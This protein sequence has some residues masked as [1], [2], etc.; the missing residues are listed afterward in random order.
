MQDLLTLTRNVTFVSRTDI[1]LMR[2]QNEDNFYVPSAEQANGAA[3]QLF[4]V[5][6]GMG[7]HRGGKM[8]SQLAVDT[9]AS[10]Y[11]T[12]QPDASAEIRIV[13][14]VQDANLKVFETSATVPEFFGMGT[15]LTSLVVLGSEAI[16][17]HVGDSR[18]YHF[19][20]G[21][22]TQVTL[23]HSLVAQA[24]REGILTPE[25]A[26]IHP[27]RNIITKALGTR[28]DIEVDTAHVALDAGDL[29]LLSSD[30]LHGLVEDDELKEIME[31][32]QR[33]LEQLS[34]ELVQAALDH[35][36][37]DNVTVVL[38]RYDGEGAVARQ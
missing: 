29:L 35:G 38:I 3:P 17:G 12:A 24:V 26:R 33:D 13:K 6:D 4:A 25:Q 20:R 14:A 22:L 16:V 31:A 32:H 10:S 27:Q 28:S 19:S 2:K 5:A 1:G 11:A 30:G 9:L 34:Q 15:T 36:G 21:R 18:L 23:D 7:G 8:A 37:S